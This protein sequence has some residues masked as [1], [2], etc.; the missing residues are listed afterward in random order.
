MIDQQE[1]VAT[2][3]AMA[4]E[5]AKIREAAKSFLLPKEEGLHPEQLSNALGAIE[6]CVSLVNI[7]TS[8][9]TPTANAAYAMLTDLT[10]ALN[11][12]P[13]W[14]RNVGSLMPLLIAAV[15]GANDAREMDANPEPRWTALREQGRHLWL[16]LLPQLVFL[17]RGHA[18][19][20]LTSV[21]MKQT[22]H[23]LLNG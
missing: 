18:Y 12:N 19:M 4:A 2:V 20:R 17:T 8:L 22:F 14:V 10:V 3:A 15:N 21:K 9:Q 7:F 23:G 13:F 1:I 11:T 6:V 5:S 16:E